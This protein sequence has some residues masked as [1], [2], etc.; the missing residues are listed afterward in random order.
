MVTS[1][2]NSGSV[3]ESPTPVD[4]VPEPLLKKQQQKSLTVFFHTNPITQ[5]M[6]AK[7][8]KNVMHSYLNLI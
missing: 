6:R 1:E 4:T 7:K 8:S 2:P 3:G 5:E